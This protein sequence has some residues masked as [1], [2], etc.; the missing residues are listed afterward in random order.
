MNFANLTR[1]EF[2]GVTATLPVWSSIS[3][4][5]SAASGDPPSSPVA[6]GFDPWLEIRPSAL[7]ANV[8]EISR[9]AGGRPVLAVI[10]NNG[11]GLGLET[12]GPVLDAHEAVSGLAVVKVDEAL[13]LRKAGVKKPVLLMGHFTPAEG[14]ELLRLDI[15]LAPFGDD[16]PQLLEQVGREAGRPAAVHF[17]IDTG[18][19]RLG[20]PYH[21]ALPWME[22]VAGVRDVRIEGTFMTFT[23]DDAFDLEQLS[24]FTALADRARA[25]RI[26]LG[27]LHA[28]S[29]HALFMRPQAHLDMVRTGLALYGAYP[30]EVPE[31]ERRG[32]EPALRLRARVVRVQQL[33]AGDSVSY[34]RAY[35]APAPTWIATIPVGHSDGYPRSAVKGCEVLIGGRLYKV[36][37]AVSASHTIVE[38][39]VEQT[40][41]VGDVATLV[42]PDHPAILP[43]AVAERAGVSVYDVL[44]HLSA[45]LPKAVV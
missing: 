15:R 24:R 25:R 13:R 7:R 16:A 33:R 40:V 12:V 19:S 43:N 1:R 10:K 41:Q 35:I 5:L 30:S 4:T 6:T 28:A 27:R 23:E 32:L 21:Q 8:T 29:S 3:P 9:R 45:E 38:L 2:V 26:P 44:M 39:G 37:G 11:Y 17:Y 20:M 36:I 14:I 34:G 42:G 22:R 31:T 18:M